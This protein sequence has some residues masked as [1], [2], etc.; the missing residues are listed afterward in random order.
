MGKALFD[1]GLLPKPAKPASGSSKRDLRRAAMKELRE[2]K[3]ED[4]ALEAYD[5]LQ[6]AGAL[7]DED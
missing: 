2:A 7:P 6:A 3:T 4:E 1:L 5:A